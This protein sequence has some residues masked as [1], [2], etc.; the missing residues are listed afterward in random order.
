[1]YKQVALPDRIRGNSIGAYG[2]GFSAGSC[3]DL[4]M[5]GTSPLRVLVELLS[6]E[7]CVQREAIIVGDQ[8]EQSPHWV[9]LSLLMSVIVM[10]AILAIH[11]CRLV[12]QLQKQRLVAEK[13]HGNVHDLLQILQSRNGTPRVVRPFRQ[14]IETSPPDY[15]SATSH[16][17]AAVANSR[18]RLG[19][20]SMLALGSTIV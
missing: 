3:V 8:A 15:A 19:S 11:H 1:M 9:V 5:N 16:F 20:M 13:L 7:M 2:K 6:E 10:L 14:E 4:C 17:H 12:L 18:P